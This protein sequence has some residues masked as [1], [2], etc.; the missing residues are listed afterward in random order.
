MGG[1]GGMGG[2]M[3]LAGF[4]WLALILGGIALVVWAVS[5]GL[6]ARGGSG[7]GSDRDPALGALRE[8][9]ARGEID[10]TEY[11]ERRRTLESG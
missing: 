2:W 5:R 8:R 9:F 4:I 7:S 6:G 1:W 10:E 3:W 11:R